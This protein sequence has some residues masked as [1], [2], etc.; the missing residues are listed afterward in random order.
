MMFV[1]WRANTIAE[2][3]PIGSSQHSK[4]LGVAHHV[5]AVPASSLPA[6]AAMKQAR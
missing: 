5:I 3:S 1:P 4:A 2:L 6:G